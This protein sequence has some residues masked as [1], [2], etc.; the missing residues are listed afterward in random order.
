SWGRYQRPACSRAVLVRRTRR[1]QEGIM[2]ETNSTLL[3][4]VSAEH[5]RIAAAQFERANQVI[6]TGNFDYGIQLLLTCSKL[7]PTHLVYRQALRR[8]EKVKYKN[9]L[10]GSRL[11]FLSSSASKAKLKAAKTSRDYLKMLEHGEEILT[12]NPWDTGTQ[13][14]MAEA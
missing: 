14:G 1:P 12:L 7:D 3:P 11:A 2:T 9:N 4:P 13:M 8:T 6:A 5:R 10:R